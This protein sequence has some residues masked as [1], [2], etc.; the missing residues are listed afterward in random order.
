MQCQESSTSASST[1]SKNRSTSFSIF[2]LQVKILKERHLVETWIITVSA[3]S[4]LLTRLSAKRKARNTRSKWI[5]TAN[6][7]NVHLWP[8]WQVVKQIQPGCRLQ[9]AFCA[10]KE[11]CMS[12]TWR[13]SST[14]NKDVGVQVWNILDS[15]LVA[16]QSL[17]WW[18]S[19]CCNK[20]LP[21][22]S[23]IACS[24]CCCMRKENHQTSH[25]WDSHL[26]HACID[27][28][29]PKPKKLQHVLWIPDPMEKVLCRI[30]EFVWVPTRTHH[31]FLQVESRPSIS[32]MAKFRCLGATLETLEFTCLGGEKWFDVSDSN[33][34]KTGWLS[35]SVAIARP[36]PI[37]RDKVDS[38]HE[39]TRQ[40]KT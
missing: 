21:G 17:S 31:I 6:L 18:R 4:N 14:K 28:L 22:C 32:S 36:Q 5:T 26:C 19:T 27:S 33:L 20:K 1:A 15:F 25:S 38:C 39:K 40:T 8:I 29:V 9:N 2:P 23:S 35:S 37:V 7:G 11:T 3:F 13:S 24:K 30:S 16:T 34:Q 12:A 10:K